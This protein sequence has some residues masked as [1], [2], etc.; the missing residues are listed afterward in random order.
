MDDKE[1][2]DDHSKQ[3]LIQAINRVRVRQRQTSLSKS[4]EV[5]PGLKLAIANHEQ[6]NL[7]QLTSDIQHDLKVQLEKMI[8]EDQLE[9]YLMSE[10]AHSQTMQAKPIQRLQL[11]KKKTMKKMQAFLLRKTD[12][13]RSSLKKE[14]DRLH[15]IQLTEISLEAELEES[16]PGLNIHLVDQSDELNVIETT[17]KEGAHQLQSH[18]DLQ[19]QVEKIKSENDALKKEIETMRL[20]LIEMKQLPIETEKM[21]V[22]EIWGLTEQPSDKNTVEFEACFKA[23]HVERD[24]QNQM[25]KFQSLQSQQQIKLDK[26]LQSQQEDTKK[27]VEELEL[28]IGAAWIDSLTKVSFFALLLLLL[29]LLLILLFF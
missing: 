6:Q 5:G 15:Q 26:P 12:R 22:A 23:V 19:V 17:W 18:S 8:Q 27:T 20:A 2:M 11:D 29:S 10:R 16:R 7:Q 4:S 25:P 24:L 28:S 3:G 1:E 13:L 9:E 21:S 14:K